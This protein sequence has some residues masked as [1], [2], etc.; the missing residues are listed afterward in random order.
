MPC[1]DVGFTTGPIHYDRL[2]SSR[3]RLWFINA[4]WNISI[5]DSQTPKRGWYEERF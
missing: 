5:Y 2:G 4:N 3:F 1:I